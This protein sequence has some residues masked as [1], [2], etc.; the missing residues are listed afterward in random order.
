MGGRQ[1]NKLEG[2]SVIR[3]QPTRLKVLGLGLAEVSGSEEEFSPVK[4]SRG[5]MAE[6][7]L[8]E[9]GLIPAT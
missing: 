1:R 9:P 3:A 8:W 4:S 7:F 5:P 6:N 2:S